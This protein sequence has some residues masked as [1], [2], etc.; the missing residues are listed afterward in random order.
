MAKFVVSSGIVECRELA[1]GGLAVVPTGR[2]PNSWHNYQDPKTARSSILNKT[3]KEGLGNWLYVGI[4]ASAFSC[5]LTNAAAGSKE[6]A[7]QKYTA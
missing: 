1:V 5:E 6:L 4:S 2:P 7:T 3:L